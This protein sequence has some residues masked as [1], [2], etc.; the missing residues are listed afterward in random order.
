MKSARALV[1]LKAPRT[2]RAE[3][4]PSEQRERVRQLAAAHLRA[5]KSWTIVRAF[6]EARDALV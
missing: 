3:V 6:L 5:G 4:S 1:P 2:T